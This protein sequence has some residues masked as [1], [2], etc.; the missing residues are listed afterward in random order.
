MVIRSL[1]LCDMIIILR[2]NDSCYPVLYDIVDKVVIL[3]RR[4]GALKMLRPTCNYYRNVY[5]Q[6]T[7]FEYD[8]RVS[9]KY[10][11]PSVLIFE[12]YDTK[13]NGHYTFNLDEYSVI[14]VDLTKMKKANHIIFNKADK[15]I[16]SRGH[17]R[18]YKFVRN[19]EFAS[20]DA[21][22]HVTAVSTSGEICIIT[23]CKTFYA[24]HETG[25][26]HSNNKYYID[27]DDGHVLVNLIVHDTQSIV[28]CVRKT[29][30]TP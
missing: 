26:R 6:V 18:K 28:P 13:N 7:I 24:C 23:T 3:Y 10:F 21:C 15:M 17:Y 20:I 5:D 29:I 30:L 16:I 25:Y 9:A 27:K 11:H 4:G 8:R 1:G 12:K 22:G 2:D 19:I 14:E